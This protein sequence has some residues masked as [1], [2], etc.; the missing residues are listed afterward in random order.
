MKSCIERLF[1]SFILA[2]LLATAL[3]ITVNELTVRE[4]NEL[5]RRKGGG[6]HGGGGG[7]SGSGSSSGSGSGSSSSSG[8]GSG[9]RSGSGSTG[10]GSS[11]GA[12]ITSIHP[13]LVGGRYYGGTTVPFI[14][15]AATALGLS[16]VLI[17]ASSVGHVYP[18]YWGNNGVYEYSYNTTLNGTNYDVNCFCIKQEPCSCDKVEDASYFDELP[19]S[20]STTSTNGNITHVN[21]NGTLPPSASANSAPGTLVSV[22]N[23][24]WLSIGALFYIFA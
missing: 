8:S 7:R 16:A 10:S 4:P 19:K 23:L 21:I 15:G 24:A 5:V 14:A 22:R 18:G 20:I 9:G 6:S 13:S 1:L 11:R 12:G 2:A 3:P 17:G